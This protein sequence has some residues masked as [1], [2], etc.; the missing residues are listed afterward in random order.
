MIRHKDV[1]VAYSEM[2]SKMVKD[3]PLHRE[4]DGRPV[5]NFGIKQQV[6]YLPKP[7]YIYYGRS[8]KA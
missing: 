4:P 7:D 8:R 3:V 6:V 1:M 5:L 2:L